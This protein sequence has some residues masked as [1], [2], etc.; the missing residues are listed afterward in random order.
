ML[1][2]RFI[3]SQP[4]VYLLQYKGGMLRREGPGLSFFYYAPTTALVAVPLSSFEEPFIFNEVTA[5]FQEVSL[6][7]QITY[8]ITD[9]KKIATLLDFTLDASGK[10]YSSEDPK[11]LSQRVINAIQVLVRGELQQLPLKQALRSSESLVKA[12]MGGLCQVGDIQSLGLEMLGLNILAI[13]PNPDTA[14]ALEAEA[15]E[16]LLKKADEAIYTRRNSA[17]ELECS[18]KENELNTEIAVET[19]KRQVRE[20]QMEAE[21]AIQAKKNQMRA[22]DMA[23][24]VA[25]EQKNQELVALATENAKKEAD[26]R[27][28]A[29]SVVMKAVSG[30][31]GKVIQS[32]AAA[33]MEP[34]QLIASAFRELADNAQKIGEL[35]ISPDLLRHLLD[36]KSAR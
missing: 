34:E 11:K 31:D 1:G 26:A 18:I 21:R 23:A 9:P 8:R 36:K 2:I 15:R 28:Y 24:A 27:A 19:K 12:V 5:D 16:E 20:T 10:H 32:L 33:G 29:L 3:K 6:Q 22:E 35:N 30:V 4:T 14:R 17:V 7:G 13:K 25:L